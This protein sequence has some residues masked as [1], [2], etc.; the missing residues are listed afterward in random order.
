MMLQAME[1]ITD[2]GDSAL[3]LPCSAVVFAV[4]WLLQARRRAFAWAIAIGFCCAAMIALKIGLQPCGRP[5]FGRDLANPSGHAAFAAAFYGSLALLAIDRVKAAPSRIAVLALAALWIGAIAASRVAIGAHTPPEVA[6][7]LVVGLLSIVL[8]AVGRGRAAA[9]RLALP[10]IGLLLLGSA[11]A[12]HDN[13]ARSEDL[14]HHLSE[15]FY[16]STGLC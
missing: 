10:L 6:V 16:R 15:I 3:L 5:L 14:I 1:A 7:G 2:L 13:R 12:L 9:P 4:L 11:L 8:F